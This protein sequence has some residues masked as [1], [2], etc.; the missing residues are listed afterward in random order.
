MLKFA[1]NKATVE[2]TGEQLLLEYAK[3]TNSLKSIIM[4][5]DD[6]E[7]AEEYADY[8]LFIAFKSGLDTPV[9]NVEEL[10]EENENG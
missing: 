10:R 2:G 5:C 6:E 4:S 7:D 3:L 1:N 9:D 8:L